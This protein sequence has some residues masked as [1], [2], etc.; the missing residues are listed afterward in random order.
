MV[1]VCDF[2]ISSEQYYSCVLTKKFS[3]Q[4]S[5]VTINGSTGFGIV[6]SL[7]RDAQPVLDYIEGLRNSGSA[8]SVDVTYT[9]GNSS[10]TRVVHRISGPSIYDTVLESG[11]MT[12]LPITVRGGT[13][14][15]RVLAPSR[16]VLSSLLKTLRTRF[17]VVRVKRIKATPEGLV[18]PLLTEKQH[19]AFQLAYDSGYFDIPRQCSIKDISIKIGLSRVAMQERLRRAERRILSAFAEGATR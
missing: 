8:Q 3:V 14:Y 7:G 12:M 9:S 10:W 15:H 17:S 6:Q 16:D 13:Q 19:Q 5:I 4:V 11:C 2:E 1:I 18:R